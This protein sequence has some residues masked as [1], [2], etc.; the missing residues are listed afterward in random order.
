LNRCIF[1]TEC[2]M[3]LWAI[4]AEGALNRIMVCYC[5][6]TCSN[7]RQNRANLAGLV[8]TCDKLIRIVVCMLYQKNALY[9]HWLRPFNIIHSFSINCLTVIHYVRLFALLL[10]FNLCLTAFCLFCHCHCHTVIQVLLTYF[11]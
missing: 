8:Q 10:T 4:L 3:R 1:K 7:C 5:Y 11:T 6:K 2:V 9:K